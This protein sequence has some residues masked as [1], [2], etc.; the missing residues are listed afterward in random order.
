[1]ISCGICLSDLVWS[2][3]GPFMLLKMALFHSFIS[4]QIR[5]D[6]L[7]SRVLLFATPWITARQASL[8]ITNSQS[9][10]RLMSIESVML[11]NILLCIYIYI[12][13]HTHTI[14][15][16]SVHLLVTFRLL[17]V[18]VIENCSAVNTRKHVYFQI[19]VFFEYMPRSGIAGSYGSSIFSFLRHLHAVFHSGYT[20]LHS[21]WQYRRAP[22]PPHPL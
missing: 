8:S 13:T 12:Y 7:L 11:S 16:L 10:L 20:N 17:H 6:Q 5:S 22:F 19:M 1:V 21:Q 15:Y 2:S 4:D 3:L 9:S 18:L 14:S